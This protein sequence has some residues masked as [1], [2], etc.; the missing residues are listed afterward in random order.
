MLL[1]TIETLFVGLANKDILR[2]EL[3]RLFRWLKDKGVTA[4]VTAERGESSLTRSG[5]EEYLSDCV[6]LLDHHREPA[7]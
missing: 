1:D 3:R 6:I 2:S 4:V 5:L 7:R